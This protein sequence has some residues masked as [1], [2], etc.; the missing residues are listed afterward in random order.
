MKTTAEQIKDRLIK[1]FDRQ[2]YESLDTQTR[3]TFGDACDNNS[4]LVTT[5]GQLFPDFRDIRLD[6]QENGV[7]QRILN[8]QFITLSRIMRAN[9][10]PEFSQVDKWTGEV[11][12]QFFLER[13]RGTGYAD[14]DWMA[15]HV[16]TFLDGD[17]LG[18][19]VTQIGLKTN[20]KTGKQRVHLRNVPI[21]QVMWDRNERGIGRA[22][23]VCILNYVPLDIAAAMY[24]NKLMEERRMQMHDSGS[25]SPIECVRIFE[26]YDLGFGKG[27]PTMAVIPGDIDQT[28]ISVDDNPWGCLPIAH[29][30]HLLRPGMRNAT[31]RISILLADEEALNDAERRARY[32][33]KRHGFDIA[34][35]VLNPDDLERINSGEAAV[36]VRQDQPLPAGYELFTRVPGGESSNTLQAEL[37]RLDRNFIRNS[38]VTDLEMGGDVQGA[39]TLGEVQLVDARS[40]TQ[41]NWTVF[42]TAKYFERVV[43][44]VMKIAALGDED[45]TVLDIFGSNIPI[46]TGEQGSAI[47]EWLMEP[48]NIIV[49]EESLMKTDAVRETQQKLQTLEPLAPLVQAGIVDPMWYAEQ[50][51]KA[52]GYD[53]KEALAQQQPMQQDPNAVPGAQP[54][55]QVPA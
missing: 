17:G 13:S 53:P 18:T 28:P 50:T 15:Q 32:E 19:G 39:E 42:Q 4:G 51:I 21:K 22:R 6:I 55:Q 11:R 30:E 20:P 47:A 35:D 31:G 10:E 29:Y 14:G 54:Q 52:A 33:S 26:Y 34:S 24:G 8:T 48:S 12:K 45:P 5:S 37:E 41:G 38:G 43:E 36:I 25:S 27:T 49:S 23:W 3:K 1:G 44:K 46:N 16:S 2:Y 9:P 7:S 40:K